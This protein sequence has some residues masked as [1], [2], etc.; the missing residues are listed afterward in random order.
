LQASAYGAFSPLRKT[1]CRNAG[2]FFFLSAQNV[3]AVREGF[4]TKMFESC[5][6]FKSPLVAGQFVID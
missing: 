6:D 3:N 5:A 2:V 1:P 4:I